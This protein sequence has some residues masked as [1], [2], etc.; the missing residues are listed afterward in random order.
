MPGKSPSFVSLSFLSLSLS[1]F[2]F[3]SLV[4][5]PSLCPFFLFFF[6]LVHLSNSLS[7]FDPIFF[8]FSHFLHFFFFFSFFSSLPFSLF[9]SFLISFDFLLSG[10]IKAE[11]NSPHFP[12]MPLVFLTQFPYLFFFPFITLSNTWLNVSHLF[13]VHHMAHAMCH[14]PRVPCGIHMT[15]P[16]VT[17]HPIPRKT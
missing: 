12:H 2:F 1:N 14:S 15:M 8:P 11:E 5:F 9:S 6:S 17:R 13:Q 16:C 4:C 7:W 10:L 3:F